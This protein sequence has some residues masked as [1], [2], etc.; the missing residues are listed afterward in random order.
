MTQ[1]S[2]IIRHSVFDILR[3]LTTT[4]LLLVTAT[5]FAQPLG[6]WQ[7]NNDQPNETATHLPSA[8]NTATMQ[9]EAGFFAKGKPPAFDTTTPANTIWDGATFSPANEHNTSS[10]LFDSEGVTGTGAPVGGDVSVAG[11][12]KTMW[13]PDF[14]VEAFVRMRLQT[15]RHALI[16]SKRRH[17]QSDSTWSLSIDPAGNVRARFDTQPEG[18][19][20][21]RNG[22]NQ[23]FGSTAD[24]TDGQ[25][26]HVALTFDHDTQAASIYVDYVRC[27]GGVTTGPLV[28]DDSVF[29]FGRG[30]DGWLDE[31][32]LTAEVLHPEQFL[33][34]TRFFSDLKP[35]KQTV[36]MLDQTPTR[37]QTGLKLDWPN[38]GTLRPKNLDEIGT[39]MWALGC[40]TLDRDLADWDAYKKYL[41]PLGIQH[42][43]LQGGWGRTEKEKGVY[44]FQWLD[45][46]VD[47]AHAAGLAVCMETSYGNRLYEPTAGL[48]PGGKLPEG[49]ETLAAWD[50]WVD[51]MARHYSPK[52]VKQWL[53][54]NE[55]NLNRENTPEEIAVFNIRTA[56]IIKS[57]DPEAQIGALALSSVS[58]AIPTT[59]VLLNQLEAEQKTGLF[60]WIVYHHY[61]ANPDSAYDRVDTLWE[62]VRNRAPNLRLWQGEAGCA[63]EEVQYALSGVDWTEVSQAKWNARR[64]LGDLGHDVRSSVFTISDLS[65]HKDFISRYGLLKT[66]SDN[67]IIKVKTAYYVAQNVVSLF[68]DTVERVPEINV[69]FQSDA[70]I[71]S[72]AFRD[73]A[74]GLS[75]VTFWD[76]TAIPTHQC[77]T[78]PLELTVTDANFQE[79]VWLDLVTGNIY[80]I[81]PEQTSA[82]GATYTFKEMPVYDG[83]AAIADKSL[84]NFEPARQKR[85]HNNPM[86]AGTD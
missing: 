48:G 8:V 18:D 75:L 56:Q 23:S 83:P 35:R 37:V 64:M 13:T 54:Y 70:K 66:A 39:S 50:R 33:R 84:L 60:D 71:T 58:S 57:I 55:P 76:G 16:A 43:R 61:S 2:F 41:R 46:I 7:F 30:L 11:T 22:F 69:T 49:D 19:P 21:N 72:Y 25:W 4:A 17:G 42:I 80:A 51:A 5:T 12:D 40:E 74:T 1:P 44:D 47:D 68:N 77:V 28:Y 78:T 36:A 6:Y 20:N 67:K 59:E 73:K 82:D 45:H 26:H 9:A 53:M 29:V 86:A 24:L 34:K 79:P 38:I 52:G 27:G 85:K 10:L 65:Y 31:V 32:R 63:S 62:L 81:P 14:T 3:F 15:P